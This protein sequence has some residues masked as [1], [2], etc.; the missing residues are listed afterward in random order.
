MEKGESINVMYNRFN[1]IVMA[2]QNLGRGL[3]LDEMNRKLLA[4]LRIE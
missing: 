2:L 4:A 3:G 1:D